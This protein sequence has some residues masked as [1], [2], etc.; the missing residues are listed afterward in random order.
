MVARR[1][2][3]GSNPTMRRLPIPRPIASSC[4]TSGLHALDPACGTSRQ[5]DV[6]SRRRHGE[7]AHQLGIERWQYAAA[8]GD[9]AA[10]AF[11]KSTAAKGVMELVC[12]VSSA[13]ASRAP[14]GSTR[15]DATGSI[16]KLWEPFVNAIPKEE[17][18]TS[19]APITAAFH[20]RHRA[21]A[22]RPHRSQWEGATLSLLPDPS[23]VLRFGE[24]HYALAFARIESHYFV[25]RGFFEVDG[26][27]VRDAGRLHG[28]P[29]VIVHGRYDVVTPMR[30]AHDLHKAWPQARLAVVP[31]A[32][33]AT[34]ESGIV[35]ELVTATDG[36]R[37]A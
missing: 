3:P 7:T 11:R 28:L 34:T 10:L 15:R 23:R 19:S 5:H 9:R 6:G 14:V 35:H 37:P 25:N 24:E 36:F 13:A 27:L 20:R 12:A 29:G 32:G 31:D 18:A 16:P 17:R 33:H 21:A 1:T 8:R 22:V 2:R 26:Q 30:N 4:S